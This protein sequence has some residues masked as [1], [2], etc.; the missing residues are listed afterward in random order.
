V[1]LIETSTKRGFTVFNAHFYTDELTA[2]RLKSAAMVA[3]AIA[4]RSFPDEPVILTG[5]FNSPED[6]TVTHWFKRGRGNPVLLRDTYRDFDPAGPVTTGFGTKFDYIYAP[7]DG[8]YAT[9]KAW[10]IQNP[11]GASDHMPI[12][13]DLRIAYQSVALMDRNGPGHRGAFALANP[14]LGRAWRLDGKR[15]PSPHP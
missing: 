4:H 10:V 1:R 14:V 11:A 7:A 15:R 12:A 5:D 13:A 9:A 8:R 6:D 2:Y 3:D